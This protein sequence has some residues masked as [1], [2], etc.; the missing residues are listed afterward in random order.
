M[1]NGTPGN[2]RIAPDAARVAA[3][4]LALAAVACRGMTECDDD[5]H[6]AESRRHHVCRWLDRLGVANELEESESSLIRTPLGLLD[7]QSMIDASWRSEGM[8]V[9]AWSLGR[10]ELPR[11]DDYDQYDS[12]DAANKLGFLA[13]RSETVLA[14]PLLRARAEIAHW[15]NTYLTVHWRLRQHSIDRAPMDLADY[16]SQCVWGPLTL[17]EVE[18]IDGDLGIRGERIDRVPYDWY[19]RTFSVTRERHQ[20]LNWLLGFGPA[21]SEVAT[22]T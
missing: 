19:Y 22:D 7:R 13:E 20:A 17:A 12:F 1:K 6:R 8:L 9:L 5:K 3:R 10:V 2:E 21:Y 14:R 18:L 15:A 11:Y 16:V 4:A